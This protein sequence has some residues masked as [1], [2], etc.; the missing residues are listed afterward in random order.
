MIKGGGERTMSCAQVMYQPYVPYLS[1]YDRSAAAAAAAAAAASAAA[2]G[3]SPEKKYRLHHDGLTDGASDNMATNYASNY[4]LLRSNYPSASTSSAVHN[5]PSSSNTNTSAGTP[6][7]VGSSPS[8][9]VAGPS[10]SAT[11]GG[12]LML[13]NVSPV[14]NRSGSSSSN[15]Q[16][17]AE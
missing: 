13:E 7:P 5:G 4:L 9:P 8:S 10:S 3:E 12:V 11:S 15:S 2:N 17:L 16:H 14:G 6:V 1:S